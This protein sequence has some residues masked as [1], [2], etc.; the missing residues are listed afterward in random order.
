MLAAMALVAPGGASTVHSARAF[1]TA[2]FGLSAGDMARIDNW[3]VVARTLDVENR[4]EVATLGIIR[5]KTTP[6]IYVEHLV[7]IVQF[8]RTDGV[9]QIGTFGTPAKPKDVA[10]LTLDDG[11]LKR[12]RECRVGDCGVR[13]PAEGIERFRREIDW[14]SADASRSAS[15]LFRELLVDYVTRYRMSGAAATMEYAG[16]SSILNVGREFASLV[17]A[18]MAI[19]KYA[20]RLRWHLLEYPAA[21]D[22]FTSDFIYWSKELV[23]RRPV[24]S[25]THVVIAQAG[26]ESPVRYAIGSKQIYAAH[27]F[28]ASLGLTL[29]VRDPAS[30]DTYVVYLNRT[31]IDL[32]DGLF[33]GVA[34]RI[35]AGKAQ[36]LVARQLGR[37]Q[38][39]FERQR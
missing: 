23:H 26:G 1:L 16:T 37:L 10:A 22:E 20:P 36:S 3:Q 28:D 17:D 32:F 12:L 13:L 38:K 11:D 15:T 6:E 5:I 8:K 9:L 4:R 25:L 27:Y 35:A 7:D 33:G 19:W 34:R 14:Q 31:R 2:A 39:V 24:I 18:E 29:L 30:P 21:A